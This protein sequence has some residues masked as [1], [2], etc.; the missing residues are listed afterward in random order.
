VFNNV[1]NGQTLFVNGGSFLVNYG[2]GSTFA[3][4]SLVLSNFVAVPEPTTWSM[5]LAGTV[6]CALACR[7]RKR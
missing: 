6:A 1:A 2:T 4:N 7:R 3:A 5:L